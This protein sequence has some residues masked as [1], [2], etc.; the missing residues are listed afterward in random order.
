MRKTYCIMLNNKV[1]KVSK[2]MKSLGMD[3]EGRV[4]TLEY[5]ERKNK[6]REAKGEFFKQRTEMVSK[7]GI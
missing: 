5:Q 1:F 3:L 2:I 7:H 6:V 4:R